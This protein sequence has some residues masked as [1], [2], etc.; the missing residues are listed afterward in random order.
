M[1]MAGNGVSFRMSRK[2]ACL[3]FA[4]AP[5]C[6]LMVADIDERTETAIIDLRVMDL[7]RPLLA[8]FTGHLRFKGHATGITVSRRVMG[9]KR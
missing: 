8:V 5:L 3:Q 2:M 1:A 9:H 6:A 7:D 4:L